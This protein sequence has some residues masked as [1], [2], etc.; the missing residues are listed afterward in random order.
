[1]KDI[2]GAL[3]SAEMLIPFD[4]PSFYFLLQKVVMFFFPLNLNFKTVFAR[5]A[6]IASYILHQVFTYLF[7]TTVSTAAETH[8]YAV[9][10][11]HFLF[12]TAAQC[13][14]VGTPRFRCWFIYFSFSGAL[15][16]LNDAYG[17]VPLCW[18]HIKHRFQTWKR[19]SVPNFTGSISLS[20]LN[21]T[22]WDCKHNNT[23]CTRHY[24]PLRS[25]EMTSKLQNLKSIQYSA[26]A[27][28]AN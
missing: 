4:V 24:L 19:Q 26:S 28:G 5:A 6:E 16:V 14:L 10:S 1:M 2:Q 25:Q 13:Q 11:L 7:I 8:I 17:V 20:R 12:S 18:E 23:T 15:L 3:I 22:W 9:S 21:S 27:V